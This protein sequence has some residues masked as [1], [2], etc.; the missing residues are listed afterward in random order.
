[1]KSHVICF[2]CEHC[3]QSFS[4][5]DSLIYHL[6]SKH[7]GEQPYKC[8]DCQISFFDNSVLIHHKK[9]KIHN[10]NVKQKT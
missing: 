7:T 4:R 10:L 3:E 8:N 5:K 6:R 1:M 2:Y 9:L